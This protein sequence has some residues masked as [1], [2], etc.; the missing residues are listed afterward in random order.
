M[1]SDEELARLR[2]ICDVTHAISA[3]DKTFIKTICARLNVD[4]DDCRK[5]PNKWR[6]AAVQSYSKMKAEQPAEVGKYELKEGTD[7]IFGGVRVNAALMNDKLG[8]WLVA[9]GFPVKY[10]AKLPE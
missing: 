8:A 9:H 2:E 4:F 6:D 5:C 10:W 7:V 1:K 3:D